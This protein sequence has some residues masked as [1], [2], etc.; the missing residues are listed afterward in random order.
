MSPDVYRFLVRMSAELRGSDDVDSVFRHYLRQTIE[1]FGAYRGC[2][3]TLP[4]GGGAARL[5]FSYPARTEWDLVLLGDLLRR[6]DAVVPDPL[7]VRPIFRR[8]RRWG[9]LVLDH[10]AEKRAKGSGVAM[11]SIAGQLSDQVTRLDRER[12][13]VVRTRIDGKMVQQLPPKDLYYQILDGL[14]TLTHYDH[15]SGLL[16]ADPA[17]ERLTLVAEQVAWRKGKST[18]IGH[19]IPLPPEAQ[20]LMG[21]GPVYAFDRDGDGWREWTSH[22]AEPLQRLLELDAQPPEGAVL[23]APLGTRDGPLGFLK[24]SALSAG[25]FGR[26]EL[27]ALESFTP[28]AAQVIQRSQAEQAMYERVVGAERK[29]AIADI[30]RGVAHDINNALGSVLPLVQQMRADAADGRIS[31]EQLRADLEQIEQSLRVCQRIFGGML[32]FARGSAKHVG[33][34]D[35][36]RA[37]ES[38]LAVLSDSLR[39][40]GIEVALELDETLPPVD[41]RQSD[42]EQ[43]FLNLATNAR[44]AMPQG[45]ALRVRAG[46]DGGDIAIAI[47]DSG[48]GIPAHML[49]RIAEPFFSTKSDGTGLG[50][51]TCLSIVA[52]LGGEMTIASEPG[53]GTTVSVR[54]PAAAA[55]EA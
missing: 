39:R 22:G 10:A 35:V 3:V 34:G 14:H 40:Q 32:T 36:R 38:T 20:A 4:P 21:A 26:W 2:I 51:P 47:A 42:L 49:S 53:S 11:T 43:V 13:Y 6:E 55:V 54:I 5:R 17:R 41:G 12:L 37:I 16:I 44:E 30:A 45:G 48:R 28:L 27:D 31:P 1:F 15:S 19:E 9:L 25:T 23:L 18:R 50:L 24:L 33:Q 29:H 7:R 52:G 8:G 46:V